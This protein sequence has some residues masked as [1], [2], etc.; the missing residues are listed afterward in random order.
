MIR[1]HAPSA[2]LNGNA[3]IFNFPR[4]AWPGVAYPSGKA[5]P[6]ANLIREL[7]QAVASAEPALLVVKRCYT[8][9]PHVR[10]AQLQRLS[11]GRG[12]RSTIA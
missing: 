5:R 11:R 12:K 7:F 1:R 4:T 3:A 9:E 6:K 10:V 2:D 8:R